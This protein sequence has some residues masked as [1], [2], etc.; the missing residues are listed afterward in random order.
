MILGCRASA[1]QGHGL[2]ACLTPLNGFLTPSKLLGVLRTWWEGAGPLLNC[3]KGPASS[4]K[5]A[6]QLEVGS[7]NHGTVRTGEALLYR[8]VPV[9]T[10][11]LQCSSIQLKTQAESS[12]KLVT[13]MEALKDW[14]RE[15]M[16]PW[17]TLNFIWSEIWSFPSF[18]LSW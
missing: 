5:P 2:P 13:E 7:Y 18:G 9:L 14:K 8:P 6:R 16:T 15:S 4:P 10:W 3:F 1:R 12:W 11:G 17:K